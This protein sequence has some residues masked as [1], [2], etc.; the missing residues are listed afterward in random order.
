MSKETITKT[1]LQEVMFELY[2]VSN[3]DRKMSKGF[4]KEL[5]NK[6]EEVERRLFYAKT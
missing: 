5:A 3:G 6:L 1:L 2:D 4:A